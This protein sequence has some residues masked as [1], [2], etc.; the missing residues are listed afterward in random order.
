MTPAIKIAFFFF[1]II[2]KI[3]NEFKKGEEKR[4]VPREFKKGG[5]SRE[6]AA[7]T[8]M[9]T[10]KYSA[11][12]VIPFVNMYLAVLRTQWAL[13]DPQFAASSQGMH[14]Q[15]PPLKRGAQRCNRPG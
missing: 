13:I 10:W 2:Q 7:R 15:T 14:G 11:E 3:P 12:P 1:C 5:S 8:R 6:R 4:E 9:Q